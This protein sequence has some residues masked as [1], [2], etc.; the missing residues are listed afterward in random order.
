M[1]QYQ[2]MKPVMEGMA[3]KGMRER[4]STIR[5]L[6]EGALG[7]PGGTGQ[8][9]KRSTGKRLSASEKRQNR[10]QREKELRKIRRQQKTKK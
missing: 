5:E 9:N 2:Q 10:K 6:Q 8:K 3:G 1:K 4:M 7:D